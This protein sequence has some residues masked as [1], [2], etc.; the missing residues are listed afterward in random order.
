MLAYF[1]L[2]ELAL[3]MFTD[4]VLTTLAVK[5]KAQVSYNKAQEKNGFVW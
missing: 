5:T 2:Y 3:I 1:G 4:A